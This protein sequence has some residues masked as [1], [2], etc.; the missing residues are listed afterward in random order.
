MGEDF[1]KKN[2]LYLGS[3][4]KMRQH[5]LEL[6]QIPYTVLKQTSDECSVNLT[7][8][9]DKYVLAIA[10]EK[11]AHVVIPEELQTKNLRSKNSI[12]VLTADTLMRLQKSKTILG[13]PNDKT[14]A[15]RMLRLMREEPIELVT[16]CCLEQKKCT[17]NVW[18]TVAQKHWTTPVT[19]EFCV[20][21]E[22]IDLY[23]EKMPHALAACGAG[24]IEDFGMNF[25]KRIDGSFTA[26]LGLPL[27][28]LRLKLK[29][30]GFWETRF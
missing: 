6:A 7:G 19:L 1:M 3:Q 17:D 13:K 20:A 26:I 25:L 14:D 18:Q 8:S 28:E 30:M 24:I 15:K 23:F 10:Q 4:S 5:L 21:D 27:F 29:E 9:F 12:F 11:M 22:E 16:G 2:K